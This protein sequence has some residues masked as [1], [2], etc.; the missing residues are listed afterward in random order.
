M[1]YLTNFE[2]KGSKENVEA[3]IAEIK[4]NSN[5]WAQWISLATEPIQENDDYVARFNADALDPDR[6]I[7]H[8]VNVKVMA[9]LEN[10]HR[11]RVEIGTSDI[12]SS[13]FDETI[14]VFDYD[15][16]GDDR[17]TYS[18]FPSESFKDSFLWE[19][20]GIYDDIDYTCPVLE[21]WNK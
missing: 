8:F 6:V 1:L 7:G 13:S 4:N 19:G 2:I 21:W 18:Y 10:W 17:C 20:V 12:G 14:P 5:G 15:F 3:I 11:S 9:F 16:H